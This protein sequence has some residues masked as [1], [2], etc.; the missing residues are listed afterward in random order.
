ISEE[1]R[2]NAR[3]YVRDL[4]KEKL[5]LSELPVWS[6]IFS[7]I[8][9]KVKTRTIY[10][11]LT[12][13]NKDGSSVSSDNYYEIIKN[14]EQL[15]NLQQEFIDVL[16]SNTDIQDILE[17]KEE[18]K[19]EEFFTKTT[20]DDTNTT[21]YSFKVQGEEVVS[22]TVD[23]EEVVENRQFVDNIT[24]IT[25]TYIM[26]DNRVSGIITQNS[27]GNLL[28]TTTYVGKHVYYHPVSIKTSGTLS[29]VKTLGEEA[30]LLGIYDYPGIAFETSEDGMTTR[31]FNDQDDSFYGEIEGSI[32]RVI[33]NKSKMTVLGKFREY[34]VENEKGQQFIIEIDERDL[35]VVVQV[36]DI[37]N[38]LKG[39]EEEQLHFAF[40]DGQK[41]IDGEKGIDAP[42]IE[43]K[44]EDARGVVVSKKDS[45]GNFVEVLQ[46]LRAG[47]AKV[48]RK[49]DGTLEYY[50]GNLQ[51][52][53]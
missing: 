16:K 45:E 28:S 42:I 47:D 36:T 43:I 20:F 29:E 19:Q 49:E 50:R 37:T 40:V 27:E 11:S 12:G 1:E 34:I 6:R 2:M 39:N 46:I 52:Q 48:V 23:K 26:K 25:S 7:A 13:K 44:R 30:K 33:H 4:M 35:E 15:Q 9:G 38:E 8:R 21:Q 18:V 31:I 5:V 22:Y 32:K 41:V 14:N 17:E 24:G 51:F 3:K 10:E 53:V